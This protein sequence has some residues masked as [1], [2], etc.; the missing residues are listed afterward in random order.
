M[1]P[2]FLSQRSEVVLGKTV[3]VYISPV[4]NKPKLLCLHGGPG[5]AA[6]SIWGGFE[7]L[8]ERFDLG[9][10]DFPSDGLDS[11]GNPLDLYGYA[12]LTNALSKTIWNNAGAIGVFGHSFGG[13][14]AIKALSITKS[15]FSFGIVLSTPIDRNWTIQFGENL[16]A[17]P[18]QL[19][20]SKVNDDFER[21]RDSDEAYRKLFV[22]YAQMYLN[23][24]PSRSAVELLNSWTYFAKAY[25][26]GD[27]TI[28]PNLNLHSDLK[29]LTAPLLCIGADQDLVVPANDADRASAIA[30]N[31]KAVH[32][33]GGH[34][35]LLTNR[36]D[37][38]RFVSQWWET[39]SKEVRNENV[40]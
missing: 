11:Q 23:D 14:V 35:A 24:V 12:Q 9:F 3:N 19:D 26:V 28:F 15:P 1:M 29:A 21:Q 17:L 4:T 10:I 40:N 22:D 34:F 36:A 13:C 16:K 18:T 5:L 27:R 37:F 31:A 32:I 39:V 7:S 8:L 33:N 25:A 6:D 30:K 38:S 2:T 20:W